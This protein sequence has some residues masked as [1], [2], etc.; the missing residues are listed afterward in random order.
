MPTIEAA[1]CW[2][3]ASAPRSSNCAASRASGPWCC[4]IMRPRRRRGSFESAVARRADQAFYRR[5]RGR[6]GDNR[7]DHGATRRHTGAAGAPSKGIRSYPAPDDHAD[8]RVPMCA[9]EDAAYVLVPSL[10]QRLPA[11]RLPLRPVRRGDAGRAA[12]Q[13]PAR[14]LWGEPVD[15]V[16]DGAVALTPAFARARAVR[17]E[18]CDSS[19]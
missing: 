13:H 4:S 17:R 2:P 14:L 8:A 12:N 6:A 9:A 18:P 7:H 15:H 19:R 5:T 10:S 16:A 1:G 11:H 3:I